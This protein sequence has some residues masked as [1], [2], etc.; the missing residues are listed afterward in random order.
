MVILRIRSR[1][2][3]ACGSGE[4]ELV[5]GAHHGLAEAYRD[6]A[7]AAPDLIRNMPADSVYF[8]RVS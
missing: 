6:I 7:W 1:R 8:D 2:S 5:G 4:Q 3:G